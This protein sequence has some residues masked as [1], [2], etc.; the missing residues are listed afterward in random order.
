MLTTQIFLG[1]KSATPESFQ[2]FMQ[3]TTAALW[4]HSEFASVAKGE[5]NGY[6][7]A[8]WIQACP[9]NTATGKPKLT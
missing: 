1:L 9:L 4:E 8:V 6:P 7:F 5:E 2:S 3:K